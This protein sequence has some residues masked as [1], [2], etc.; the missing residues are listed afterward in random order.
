MAEELK[1]DICVIGG[2]PAGIRLAIA[3]AEA[4][5]PVVL[6]EKGALGGANF[7]DGGIPAQA[8]L[9]A[10]NH[11][12]TLRR[13]PAFGVTA[14][15]LAIDFAG[16]REHIRA[17]RQAIAPT[18]SA[19]RLAALGI[20]VI[21]AE[22]AFTDRK[23][24]AA[25]ETLIR[26]RRTVI[27]TG[28]VS[29]P[30]TIAGLDKVPYLTPETAFDLER[31]PARLVVLGADHR[32]LELA[33]AYNRLGVETAVVDEGP[34]LAGEDPELAAI[35]LD[36]LRAEGIEI[37]DNAKITGVGK[38]NGHFTVSLMA[39]EGEVVCDCSHILVESGRRPRIE[40]LGLDAAGIMHDR[41]GITV[42]RLLKTTNRRVYAIGNA[43][44]GPSLVSRAEYEADYVARAILYRLPFREKSQRTPLVTFTDPALARLGLSEAEA[45]TRHRGVRVLRYPFLENDLAQA[46]RRSAGMIKV[47]TTKGGRILGAGIVGHGGGELIALWSLAVARGLNIADLARFAPPYPSRAE[48]ARRAAL[49]FYGPGLT[50]PWRQRI[51]EFLRKF[52]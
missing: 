47:I 26:A 33:Q 10:A 15:S 3:A 34:A 46:E 32:A 13:G 36:R 41:T 9:A 39:A 24:V 40:G 18:L 37:R 30:P 45:D 4:G 19:E 25:G 5:V 43:I 48:I 29:S 20:T 28:A 31:K 27:A 49:T 16:V 2:G 52:G 1:P 44:A 8:L 7:L 11:Y 35:V 42:D 14:Q 22:A 21:S 23:T 50:P 6:V 38:E 12:E 17:V 51:I